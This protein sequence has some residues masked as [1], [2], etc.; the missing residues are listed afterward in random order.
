M[1]REEN[2]L[3]GNSVR[4][5]FEQLKATPR[6]RTAAQNNRCSSECH[7]LSRQFNGL[8]RLYSLKAGRISHSHVRYRAWRSQFLGRQALARSGI[9]ELTLIDLD[10]ICVS[11]TNR[12]LHALDTNL[13]SRKWMSWLA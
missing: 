2:Q 10:D 12:Q 1:K 11:N 8:A 13:G 3:C 6:R 4:F 7:S 9:G 5:K